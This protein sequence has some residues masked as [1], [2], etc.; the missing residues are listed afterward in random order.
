MV[1][2]ERL[3]QKVVSEQIDKVVF[4]KQPARKDT[5]EQGVPFVV[6]Y[7]P[8][9]KDLSK[10]IKN[11]QLLLY[12]D[13]EVQRV[14]SPAAIVSYRSA[15]KIKDYIVR[16]KLYSTERR[17]GSFR[18]GKLR[19]QLCTSI[20]VTDTFCNFATKSSYKINHNFN[21]NSKCL[22]YLLSYKACSKQ[23][24]GKTTDKFRSR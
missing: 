15:R 23:Y 10:L 1:F 3:L 13:S 18:C 24:T 19:C 2:G 17:D 7:H 14:F 9:L 4:G 20:Q 16:S 6:T 8:K 5:S 12:S 11:L 22:I 21:S